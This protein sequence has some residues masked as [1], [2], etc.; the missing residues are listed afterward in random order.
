MAAV[1][2]VAVG[3]G[4]LHNLSDGAATYQITSW[5]GCGCDIMMVD[6]RIGVRSMAVGVVRLSIKAQNDILE[7]GICALYVQ[8]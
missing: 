2:T 8:I 6:M 1:T 7:T 4:M 3:T 5:G